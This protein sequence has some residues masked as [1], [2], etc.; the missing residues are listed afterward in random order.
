MS[1]GVRAFQLCLGVLTLFLFSSPVVAATLT[2]ASCSAPAVQAAINSA[3]SGDT[4]LVPA[5]TCTWPGSGAITITGNKNITLRGAGAGLTIINGGSF[6]IVNTAP[7]WLGSRITG[8]TFNL[9]NSFINIEGAIDFR[10]D[11]NTIT[12][13]SWQFCIQT[14]GAQS[15][16][17]SPS[18]SEGLIDNNTLE[19]CRVIAFGEYYDTGGSD[20]WLEPLQ[21]GSR[22]AIYLEDNTYAITNCP[23]GTSGVLCN[24]VDG[25]TGGRFVARFNTITNSYFE[26]HS[27]GNLTRGV[28]LVEIY[29]NTTT[30]QGSALTGFSRPFFIRAGTSMIFH[31]TYNQDFNDPNINLDNERSYDGTIIW[32]LCDGTR[33]VDSNELPNGWLCR[34]QIG[35][36]GDLTYWGSPWSAPASVQ[37]KT[38]S[39]Y[40]RNTGPSGELGINN[41]TVQIAENRDFYRYRSG[42]NGTVGAGEG[43]LAGRPSTCTPGVAYWATDQGEWNSRQAGPDGQLYKCTAPNTW[44]LY[45]IPYPYPHPL[46]QASGPAPSAPTSLQVQ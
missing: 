25:N 30:L 14:V 28:R 4:V 20:R 6:N 44:S 29:K 39:Y 7:P 15:G 35:A 45:Y 27:A 40:W 19:N 8:F 26:A 32:G 23:Q 21:L 31:N 38:P 3:A 37:T 46:Q 11:H 13:P 43:P 42:F 34:D 2:A 1:V 41:T 16:T 5:G 24:F 33:F 18:P 22:H 36:G 12:E 9:G 10:I 17:R